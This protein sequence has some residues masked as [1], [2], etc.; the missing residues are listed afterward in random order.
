MIQAIITFKQGSFLNYEIPEK[1]FYTVKYIKTTFNN[2]KSMISTATSSSIKYSVTVEPDG[3]AN[4][5]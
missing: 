3:S 1:G 5:F 4:K 2:K